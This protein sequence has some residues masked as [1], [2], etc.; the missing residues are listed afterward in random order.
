[1]LAAEEKPAI[2]LQRTAI[3]TNYVVVVAKVDRPN[4][5]NASPK[6]IPAQKM[7]SSTPRP[8]MYLSRMGTAAIL[9][10][11]G[12]HRIRPTIEPLILYSSIARRGTNMGNVT[13]PTPSQQT[14]TQ[15]ILTTPSA[16]AFY[17]PS[18]II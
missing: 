17:S 2:T 13:M 16:I 9:V 12:V 4:I 3:H 8:I 5:M 7:T 6:Q 10:K 1:M 15:N 14:E 18:M 11:A